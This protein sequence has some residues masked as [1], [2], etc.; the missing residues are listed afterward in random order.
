LADFSGSKR[1]V[2]A[3]DLI[4]SFG[5]CFGPKAPTLFLILC[6]G[7]TLTTSNRFEC[8]SMAKSAQ[9]FAPSY[10][11]IGMKSFTTSCFACSVVSSQM[12]AFR[13][14][15]KTIRAQRLQQA[16]TLGVFG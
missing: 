3:M 1:A 14:V 4:R 10:R 12:R 5:E 16:G 13:A 7:S 11:L 2:E 6:S 9:A 15:G 8:S